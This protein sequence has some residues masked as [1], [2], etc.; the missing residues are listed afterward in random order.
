LGGDGYKNWGAQ[1]ARSVQLLCNERT[2][3]DGAMTS[4]EIV[5]KQGVAHAECAES[6]TELVVWAGLHICSPM[7]CLATHGS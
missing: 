1:C 4:R 2:A 7:R 5:S 3:K 6:I